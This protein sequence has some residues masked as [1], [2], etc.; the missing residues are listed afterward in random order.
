MNR[1]IFRFTRSVRPTKI[2]N[3]K[4]S[5]GNFGLVGLEHENSQAEHTPLFAQT[6]TKLMLP[7]GE[8]KQILDM[9]FGSGFHS[10]LLLDHKQGRVGKLVAC[11]CDR[12]CYNEAKELWARNPEKVVA[13]KSY[14][15]N[16]PNHLLNLGF[17]PGSFDGILIDAGCSSSQYSDASRGFCP[18][19][20]GILDLRYNPDPSIPTG[21]EI[22][23][24]IKD[25]DLFRLLRT[26]S[27]LGP[28]KSK[29]VANAIIESRYLFHKFKT[30]QELFEVIRTAA[31]TFC[32]D[33]RSRLNFNVRK[34][35]NSTTMVMQ[36]IDEREICLN[37]MRETLAALKIFVNNDVNELHF[38]ISNVAK[39]FLKPKSGIL[40]TIVS[41]EAER[42]VTESA[43]K[44]VD[45]EVFANC[46][47]TTPANR[48]P[49]TV[50]Q[51]SPQVLTAAEKTLNPRHANAK[52][53]A[54]YLNSTSVC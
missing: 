44:E 38:A 33:S 1:T 21:S 24:H 16:L 51:P 52:L 10:R 11:D 8:E 12:N 23:Q 50:V 25:R 47:D 48:H 3:R 14:F 7:D 35:Y 32:Q 22:L 17:S 53:Y 18:T 30:T 43:L 31:E 39:N 19:R 6:I 36:E 20:P 41:T 13:L 28:N 4:F 27:G 45:L 42:K 9:T 5:K 46:E 49:W 15:H 29:Y 2:C 54:A 37:M 40:I 26:Y 34:S